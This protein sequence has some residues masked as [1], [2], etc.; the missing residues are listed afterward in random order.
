MQQGRKVEKRGKMAKVGEGRRNK[1][2]CVLITC[3]LHDVIF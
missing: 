2:V 1:E 3:L